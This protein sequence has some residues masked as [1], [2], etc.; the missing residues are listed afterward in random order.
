MNDNWNTRMTEE[1]RRQLDLLADGELDEARRRELLAMLD[2]RPDGWRNCAL[3]FLEAQS[4]RSGSREVAQ[5]G[6]LSAVAGDRSP[7]PARPV[8]LKLHRP[9]RERLNLV[10]AMAASFLAAFALSL[11]WRGGLHAPDGV[12]TG[13]NGVEVAGTKTEPGISSGNRSAV[14]NSLDSRMGS[15]TLAADG[16]GGS[17]QVPYMAVDRFDPGLLSGQPDVVPEDLVRE[18]KRTGHRVRQSRQLVP[19]DLQDGR[20]LLLPVDQMDVHY[21]GDRYQ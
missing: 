3:A 9:S 13:P 2:E 21:V 11:F 16:A 18:L 17:V 15:V 8:R 12:G 4:W 20:R 19:I 10:L 7:S 14:G 1:E 5:S 6:L